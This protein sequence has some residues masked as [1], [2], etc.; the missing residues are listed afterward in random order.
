MIG[1]YYG[2]EGGM[3]SFGESRS[4]VSTDCSSERFID[5]ENVPENNDRRSSLSL[6]RGAGNGNI[7]ISDLE[8]ELYSLK[9]N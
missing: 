2:F 3:F 1:E 6:F 7:S 5:N 9:A 4:E 8:P